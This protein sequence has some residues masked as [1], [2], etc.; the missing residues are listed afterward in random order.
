MAK[1][2]N[3]LPPGF[4]EADGWEVVEFKDLVDGDIIP[5]LDYEET[6]ITRTFKSHIPKDMY[7]VESQGG[8]TVLASGNHLWYIVRNHDR[9]TYQIRLSDGAK[10]G[11]SVTK[12]SIETL[13]GYAEAEQPREVTLAQMVGILTEKDN[14]DA[15]KILSRIAESIGPVSE[16]R[17]YIMDDLKE[18]PVH[19]ITQQKYNSRI[20]AQQILSVLNL[21]R[22]YRKIWPV[23]LG[24]VVTTTQLLDEDLDQ[25]IIPDSKNDI[26]KNSVR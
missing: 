11:R 3:I 17:G 15:H 24:S 9:S 2:A 21:G 7:E 14:G 25:I 8:Q 22:R 26:F 6:K 1:V 12:E 4:T 20:F 16:H 5:G 10:Y 13:L 18:E 23:I 19:M